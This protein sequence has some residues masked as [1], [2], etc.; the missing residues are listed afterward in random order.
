MIIIFIVCL[1]LDLHMKRHEK[2]HSA[3]PKTQLHLLR[4]ILQDGR[5]ASAA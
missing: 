4:Q 1:I 3:E 5:N 2:N